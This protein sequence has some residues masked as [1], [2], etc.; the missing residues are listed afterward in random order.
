MAQDLTLVPHFVCYSQFVS[1]DLLQ[2]ALHPTEEG[3]G[4]VAE[5]QIQPGRCCDYG[6]TVRE[7]LEGFHAVVGRHARHPYPTEWQVLIDNMHDGI[8]DAGAA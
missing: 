2:D 4:H 1:K 3:V 6:A 8:V 5:G 7:G